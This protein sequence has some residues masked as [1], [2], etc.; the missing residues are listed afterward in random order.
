MTHWRDMPIVELCELVVDCVNKTAPVVDHETPYKMIRTTKVRGGWV[1]TTAV[2]YVSEPVFVKWTR[3]A[4][5]QGNDV[6]LTR[7]APLGGVGLLRTDE[8]V[9]LGQR[10]MMYRAAPRRADPRFLA[11]ALMSPRVQEQ[12]R[13][14]GSGARS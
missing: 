2:K 4:V 5:P 3:R 14:F 13:A 9:F 12:L 11:Y 8:H 10:L 6:L 1:D 7:E